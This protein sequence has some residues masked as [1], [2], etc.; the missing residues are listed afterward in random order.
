MYP[1]ERD[2]SRIPVVYRVPVL[3]C[4][5]QVPMMARASGSFSYLRISEVLRIASFMDYLLIPFGGHETLVYL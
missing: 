1:S 3:P 2:F 4:F 5:A